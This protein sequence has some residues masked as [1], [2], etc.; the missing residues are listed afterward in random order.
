MDRLTR[1][2]AGC[3]LALLAAAGGCRTAHDEVPPG[4]V[5]RPDGP[6]GSGSGIGFSTSPANKAPG[7]FGAPN[8][9]GQ[10]N[11]GGSMLGPRVPGGDQTGT[12][13]GNQFGAPGT[14]G[15]AMPPPSASMA[16]PPQT[17]GWPASGLGQ[18]PALGQP[19]AAPREDPN[20]LNGFP[21]QP[22]AIGAMGSPGQPPSPL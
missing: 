10:G 16:P 3:G 21:S 11:L 17:G 20:Y 5:Y 9:L 13:Q 14:S 7:M 12:F 22:P 2:L 6:P 15:A 19:S 8:N 4:K 1:T 18:A